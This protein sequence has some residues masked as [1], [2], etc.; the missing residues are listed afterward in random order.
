M[1]HCKV[2][3]SFVM[4][5]VV[6]FVIFYFRFLLRLLQQQQLSLLQVFSSWLK[7][8]PSIQKHIEA[9]KNQVQ[10]KHQQKHHHQHHQPPSTS[11]DWYHQVTLFQSNFSSSQSVFCIVA[12]SHT[13]HLVEHNSLLQH[14]DGRLL[15]MFI[16]IKQFSLYSKCQKKS[17][18][19]MDICW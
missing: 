19:L 10:N 17:R 11:L 16:G 18:L 2:S 8:R 13:T 14:L 3:R 12:L 9:P 15:R 1:Q 6:L 7:P 5:F 4:I